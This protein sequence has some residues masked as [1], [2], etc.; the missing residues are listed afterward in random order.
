M[1]R[2]EGEKKGKEER[3]GVGYKRR[4]RRVGKREERK[5]F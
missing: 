1:S 3:E 5:S 2:E 4:R